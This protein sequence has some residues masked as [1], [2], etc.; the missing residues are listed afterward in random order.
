MSEAVFWRTAERGPAPYPERADAKET[1]FDRRL[2]A[3]AAWLKRPLPTA[4]RRARA[5]VDEV[6]RLQPG[7][8]A[9][10]QRALRGEAEALRP[11]LLRQGFVPELAARSFALVRAAAQHELGMRHFPVQIMGGHTML[12]GLLAE[13]E[14][15]EGKTLTATL[16][17][18]T[19]AL[20][21]LPVH[22]VTV[23]DY[24]SGRDGDALRP[25]YAALGLTVGIARQDQDPDERR[26]AYAA[27]ITY[28]T[29]KDIG[30]DYLRDG[31]TLAS[32]RG[33]GRLLLRKML[34]LD[35]RMDRLL[36]RGLAFAIV[37]E[38]D[39]VLV[40]EA[41]T[42][43][44]I[45]GGGDADAEAEL[46]AQALGMGRQLALG[47]D[48]LVH[49]RDRSA[50][51]TLRGRARLKELGEALPATWRSARAREEL[52]QQA[53]A[54]LHLF[55][56]DV[57]Y[58]VRD[59]KVM[60]IDEYTGRVMPDRSWERGLHQLVET[61]EGCEVTARRG[62]LA[63]ITYQRLFRRYLRVAGMTG[64]AMEVAPEL[65]AVYGLKVARIPT[66]RPVLRRD[67]G[68]HLFARRER[69]W[70]AVADALTRVRE[71]GRP[72]LVGTRSVAASEEL[73]AVLAQR[74]IE[75]VVL[76]ARQDSEEAAIV[77]R[78]GEAGRVTIATNMAGRGTDIKPD[79]DVLAR[80][81]LHVILTEFHESGRIDRQLFG[82]CARQGDPGS[83]ET[84]IALDDDIFARHAGGLAATLAARYGASDRP[85]PGWAASLLK[86]R[87]Q[88]AA[89]SAN[90]ADRRATLEQD[91]RLDRA[92]AFAGAAE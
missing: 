70:Q 37:D 46:Y 8:D 2:L 65:E 58:L 83:Y 31:I 25:V 89:E 17:A 87:A 12:S 14:T 69:K 26:A 77:A 20:A 54:A 39:S 15:G 50:T 56:L 64:T 21:G 86:A 32:N 51:L 6:E 34:G 33:R 79:P 88:Q 60:I 3:A 42:P 16:P 9:L 76:N 72:V 7:I 19:A 5:L 43:L 67:E 90:A 40:D 47:E 63:R 78:A 35:D 74:G 1:A 45:S 92:L 57:H 22:V 80:G 24:L 11:L 28:C 59:G 55:E 48:F 62:T 71:T 49:R 81:G 41:R 29:N 4:L 61:K 27:D 66:N 36:L 23:N 10:G 75:H 68:V 82:R 52:A 84:V 44:I 91:K 73:A 18:A 38:A 30:F 53:V 13:M 85:L